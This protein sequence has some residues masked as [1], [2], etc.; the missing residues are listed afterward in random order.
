MRLFSSFI[1]GVETGES[2]F[3]PTG[4][5]SSC[6]NA[7]SMVTIP[8]LGCIAEFIATNAIVTNTTM[9][10][11][12]QSRMVFPIGIADV[13]TPLVSLASSLT[14]EAIFN[15]MEPEMPACHTTKPL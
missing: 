7:G 1:A 3:A 8:V 15:G 9:M 12:C 4:S 10:M 11:L 5:S 13:M 2:S 6:S 14:S